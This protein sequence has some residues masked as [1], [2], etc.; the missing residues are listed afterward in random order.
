MKLILFLMRAI[1]HKSHG[2]EYFQQKKREV[3]W[4]TKTILDN[5]I[6][7]RDIIILES[8]MFIFFKF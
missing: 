3:Y 6:T 1:S 4:L 8:S 2:S 5:Y 7:E